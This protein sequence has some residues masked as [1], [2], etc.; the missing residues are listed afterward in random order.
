MDQDTI[1]YI[2]SQRERV[3]EII[4]TQF[5]GR[6]DLFLEKFIPMQYDMFG[7]ND[8][9]QKAMYYN[10]TIYGYHEV[11]QY[12]YDMHDNAVIISLNGQACGW[13]MLTSDLEDVTLDAAEAFGGEEGV[14][15]YVHRYTNAAQ[16]AYQ[17]RAMLAPG[18]R[19]AVKTPG[20][21]REYQKTLQLFLEWFPELED[22]LTFHIEES[23]DPKEI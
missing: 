19:S 8:P 22:K 17:L 5:G 14:H 2:F 16:A 10:L 15:R 21:E 12:Q 7:L 13:I 1:Q 11:D 20:V 3:T 4:D 6:S 18:Y 23:G 9:D